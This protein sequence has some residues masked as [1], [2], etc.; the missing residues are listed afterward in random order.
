MLITI[1]LADINMRV[2]VK[3]F[4][5]IKDIT[6]K[7]SECLELP[8]GA[9]AGKLVKKLTEKYPQLKEI[10]EEVPILVIVGEAVAGEDTPLS[11]DSEIA[12]IPPVSGGSSVSIR[13]E[14]NVEVMLRSF[15]NAYMDEEGAVAVFIGRVKGKVGDACVKKL[16]YEVYEPLARRKLAEIAQK[17]QQKYGLL[18]I[19]IHHAIG[20]KK[21]GD[22]TVLIIASAN[23]R[24]KALKAVEEAIERVKKEAPI[25]KLE[26]RDDGEYWIVGDGRRI[27]RTKI[28]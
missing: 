8:E 5:L 2:C 18:R 6:G 7:E 28:R 12:V 24:S 4:S 9:T 16:I 10:S 20:E 26:V 1:F 19:E 17:L 3:Y 21:P 13:E 22:T 15:L 27:N 11:E 25:W 23:T 14:I